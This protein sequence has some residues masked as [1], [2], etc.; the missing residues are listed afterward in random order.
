MN[1][2]QKLNLISPIVFFGTGISLLYHFG[3]GYFFKLSYPYN[4]FL[5]RPEDRF[6]DFMWP[7]TIAANPYHIPRPDFQNFPTL[8][9]M[10]SIFTLLKPDLALQVFL[11]FFTLGILL[12]SFSQIEAFRRRSTLIDV[13]YLFALVFFSYPVLIAFDRANYEIVVFFCLYLYI[14]LYRRYPLISAGFLAI[15]VALKAFPVIMGLLLLSD[16]KYKEIVCAAG[17]TVMI[18]LMSYASFPGGMILNIDHHLRNLSLYNHIY[19]TGN[20]GLGFGH[21]LFGAL[22]FILYLIQ[23]ELITH[24]TPKKLILGYIALTIALLIATSI[25]VLKI[26][27]SFWKKFT[28]LVCALNLLPLVSGDYKLLHLF[29]PLY[30][31][32]HSQERLSTDVITAILFALL[33]IPKSY[34][35]LPGLPEV[36]IAVLLNPI[37]ML[38]MV[39]LIVKQGLKIHS[40]SQSLLRQT[41][42]PQYET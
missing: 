5:F 4:T 18:T 19:A 24:G 29:V 41:V 14:A 22:K 1:F 23:P 10:A 39:I 12:I 2:N 42:S 9:R 33:L 16:K 8:Y 32:L 40:P 27:K 11:G 6:M 21:S 28:L 17:I 26:E 34:W 3:V 7:Y 31:F 30:F 35:H 13:F 38:T 20:E 15:A 25:Y 37:L 36:S